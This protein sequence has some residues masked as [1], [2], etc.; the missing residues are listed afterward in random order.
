MKPPHGEYPGRRVH[1]DLAEP[2]T[3]A[4]TLDDGVETLTTRHVAGTYGGGATVPATGH[5]Y[6]KLTL[7][8]AWTKLYGWIQVR[9]D[10]T[11]INVRHIAAVRW[12][13]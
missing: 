9:P 6:W 2:I 3:V 5:G 12:E 7:D 10:L 13:E 8:R 11:K 4:H 1:M